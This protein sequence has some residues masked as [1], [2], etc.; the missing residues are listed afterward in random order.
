MQFKFSG[1]FDIP[2]V[3]HP[4]DHGRPTKKRKKDDEQLFKTSD[5]SGYK[6]RKS[7]M[8]EDVQRLP[9]DKSRG[10]I[11]AAIANNN[12]I[13]L[14]S[15]TGSGKS[16]RVPQFVLDAHQAKKQMCRIAVVETTGISAIHLALRVA[17]EREESLQL[18]LIHI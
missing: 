18:S 15:D 2:Y 6:W 10:N 9:I 8:G 4:R 12:V 11:V 13:L 14:K 1:H 17:A 5:W 3:K 16:T 7:K